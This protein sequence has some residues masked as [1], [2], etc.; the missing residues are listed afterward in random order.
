MVERMDESVGGWLL[1]DGGGLRDRMTRM[2]ATADELR[3]IQNEI[4]TMDPSHEIVHLDVSAQSVRYSEAIQTHEQINVYSGDEEPTR[5]YIVTWLCKIAGYPP[6]TLCLEHRYPFGSSNSVELDIRIALPDGSGQAYA[7]IEVKSFDNFK[8]ESAQQIDGQLFTPASKE[9]QSTLKVLA[10]AS[11]A[12]GASGE[13]S[14]TAMTIP[15][16][17]GLSYSDWN[18]NGGASSDSIPINYGAPTV[19]AR[20][21][22]SSNDLR[23][24]LG[25]QELDALRRT[26]HDRLWG[27]SRDDNQIYAWLTRLFLAKIHDEKQ[28]N[29]GDA[30]AFQIRPDGLVAEKPEVTVERVEK[31]FSAAYKRYIAT[32]DTQ[33]STVDLSSDGL[34]P[35]SELLWVVEQ[36]QDISLSAAG[37]NSGDLLGSFFEAITRDGFKQSKGLFFT[38]YNLATFMA[39]AMDLPELAE[40]KLQTARHANERLPYIIDPAC[41]SGTFLLA[42]MRLITA[43]IK[44]HRKELYRNQDVSEQ[45]NRL[46][47]ETAPNTWAKDFLYGLEKREDLTIS[48][49]VNMVLHR[50]G[51]THVYQGDGL[52]SLEKLANAHQDQRFRPS[53]RNSVYDLPVSEA[54]DVVITNPPFSITLDGDTAAAVDEN[55]ELGRQANPENLFLERWYQLLRPGGRLGAVMPESFFSTRENLQAR[56]F[57]LA[58]FKIR[59]IVSLPPQAFQPW[60][61]TR[62]SL[63]FA[64]KMT[65]AEESEWGHDFATAESHAASQLM[66]A[67]K[68]LGSAIECNS[69]DINWDLLTTLGVTEAERD[70]DPKSLLQAVQAIDPK[71]LALANLA[72][73]QNEPSPFL[74]IGVDEIGYR[75]TKRKESNRRNELFVAV[76]EEEDELMLV[77][78][79]NDANPDWIL[80]WNHETDPETALSLIKEANLWRLQPIM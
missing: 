47:P 21:C 25:R 37:V 64:E 48:T 24:D 36:L 32:S 80:R 26:L 68:Q 65:E 56:L 59:A 67:V 8:S 34:F 17:P 22:G 44:L 49:K 12:V 58:H 4:E 46:F 7:L 20:I 40:H 1:R 75:R 63:L 79:L 55:F 11:V 53:R 73:E 13:P 45:L 6:D 15:Y 66:E 16:S 41:G 29:V 38:H 76:T 77:P 61:P 27:G 60:T 39:A 50:D 52:Q 62:T 74:S 14:I 18:A 54:F 10:L 31:T 42:S 57:L 23:T 28:T 19:S 3:A 78:N 33:T 51:H 69:N 30:Y 2:P 5:A 72:A 9:N 35:Q 71:Q 70:A 43:H